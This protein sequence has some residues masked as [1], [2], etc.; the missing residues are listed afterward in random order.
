MNAIISGPINSVK[1][2]APIP[3]FSHPLNNSGMQSIEEIYRVRLA[4][5]IKEAGNQTRLS[6][7]I[8]KSPSQISQW[9]NASPDSKTQKPRV[10]SRE[11]AREIERKCDKEPGWMDQPTIAAAAGISYSSAQATAQI[12]S[13]G[14]PG[15]TVQAGIAVPLLSNAAS[16]GPGE[17]SQADD[18]VAGQLT[19]Q[20]HFV[21]EQLR[22]TSPGALRLIHGYGDSMEP[23]FSSGD[24]LLVDTGVVDHK[25]DGIYVL[26][27]HGRLFVKRVRQRMDGSFEVSSDNPGH[28]NPP[29]RVFFR[30]IHSRLPL[31]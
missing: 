10:M 20:P 13:E 23:T 9:L 25:I 1:R 22:P 2:S 21:R 17:D 15:Y 27:A 4:F 8:G 16:M 14:H 24:V 18:V 28:P 31:I 5:L 26:E 6:E 19:L 30:L 12:A 3:L 7:K 29:R 11:T